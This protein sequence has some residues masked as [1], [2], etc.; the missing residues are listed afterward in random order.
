MKK[1]L[2]LLLAT[3]L[4]VGGLLDQISWS[5]VYIDIRSPSFRKFPLAVSPFQ[6]VSPQQDMKLGDRA[7]DILNDDLNLTGFFTLIDPKTFSGVSARPGTQGSAPGE[8]ANGIDF[9]GWIGAGAEALIMGQ[10]SYKDQSLVLEA[11]LYDTVKKEMI[12]GKR[13]I[14]EIHDLSRMVHRFADEVVFA[15]TGEQSFF[16]T[17][18][19][20][21]SQASGKK[22]IS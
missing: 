11:R 10:V 7:T 3:F 22:E 21:V 14:G 19:V 2:L 16:Q 17:K 8:G 15:L 12:I 4:L 1:A 9:Q 5:K 6:A 20:Y 13:Y 18:I